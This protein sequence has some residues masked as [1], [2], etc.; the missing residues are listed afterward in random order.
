MG[1]LTDEMATLISGA[2]L[3]FAATVNADGTPNLSPKASLAVYDEDHLVFANIASPGTVAN[4]RRNPAI[5]I[6]VVDVFLRRGFRFK[7]SAELHTSG[8]AFDFVALPL[9]EKQG[10][11]YPVHEA[12]VVSIEQAS[13]LLS[14]AYLF[15]ETIEE[16]A[17]RDA[18][19]A[20]YGV[21]DRRAP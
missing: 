21:Q 5:E 7:G 8:P 10:K 6:N 13:A 3:S 15:N 2:K 20:E 4:L 1:I 19:L 17:L 11:Q 9:W 16:A 18:W 14:P 12:V